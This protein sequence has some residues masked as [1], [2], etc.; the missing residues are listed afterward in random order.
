MNK[1][2]LSLCTVIAEG[3]K[4]IPAT[5]AKLLPDQC[6]LQCTDELSAQVALL[7]SPILSAAKTSYLK[8]RNYRGLPVDKPHTRLLAVEMCLHL[9]L[10]SQLSNLNLREM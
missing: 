2:S 8:R 1:L 7:K 9:S 6:I 10:N 4:K 5:T 3:L